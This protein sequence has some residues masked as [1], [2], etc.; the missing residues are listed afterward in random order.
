MASL[1]QRR[2]SPSDRPEKRGGLG[3]RSRAKLISRG[4]RPRGSNRSP[5]AHNDAALDLVSSS[6]AHFVS[7]ESER[8]N[9]WEVGWTAGVVL[10]EEVRRR[11]GGC[12]G[13][14]EK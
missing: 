12:F 6:A 7:E 2:L 3:L 14:N 11:G 5:F 8:G 4:R 9:H 1:S 13:G 10:S